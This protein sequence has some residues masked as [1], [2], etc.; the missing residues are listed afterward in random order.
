MVVE[1]SS[2]VRKLIK[3]EL[4]EKRYKII[5]AEDGE[6]ALKKMSPDVDMV[7]TD[8]HMPNMDGIELIKKI[9][10]DSR[11]KFIPII[12]ITTESRTSAK[13]QKAKDAGATAWISKPFK[14][15]QLLSVVK[16]VLG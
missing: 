16:K 3:F 6:D 7:F 4:E 10:A 2:A 11:F 14:S 15:E 13:K 9:R 12:V 8:L 5:E 1:N